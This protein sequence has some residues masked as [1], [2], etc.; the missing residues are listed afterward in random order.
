LELLHYPT[1]TR[2]SSSK[3]MGRRTSKTPTRRHGLRCSARWSALSDGIWL[4][5]WTPMALVALRK[6]VEKRAIGLALLM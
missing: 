1:A 2:L 5:P 3:G 4:S 6:L